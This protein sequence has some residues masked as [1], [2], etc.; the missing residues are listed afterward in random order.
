MNEVI[1]LTIGLVLTTICTGI[2][3]WVK[4]R[5]NKKCN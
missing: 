2:T 3:E 4:E 5:M 1:A